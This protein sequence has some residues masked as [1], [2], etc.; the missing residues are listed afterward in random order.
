MGYQVDF[1]TLSWEQLR[2]EL[3]YPQSEVTKVVF[4]KWQALI[5]EDISDPVKIWKDGLS[6]ISQYFMDQETLMLN[7]KNGVEWVFIAMAQHLGVFQGNLNHSSLVG[8]KFRSH[9]LG[10]IASLSYQEPNFLSCLTD[11]SFYGLLCE[12]GYPSWGGLSK[13][14]LK[15]LLIKYQPPDN[16]DEDISEWI[17]ELSMLIEY[18][19][20]TEKDLI[21]IYT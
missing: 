12:E 4:N 1:Y 20:K 6:T 13:A 18:C 10:K 8:D 7:L 9:F 19:S 5:S 3:M 2:H 21:T 14:E 16:E 11:R 17:D 15:K